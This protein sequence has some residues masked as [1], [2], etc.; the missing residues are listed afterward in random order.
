MP[1][2]SVIENVI[3]AAISRDEYERLLPSL[4]AVTLP[5]GASLYRSGDVIEHV[6]FPGKALVSLVTHMKDGVAI[7]VGVIGRDGIVGIPV[8]LGNDI[9]SEEA[10]VQIAGSAMR[11]RSTVLKQTLQGRHSA[12]LIQL[13]LYTRALMK[14]VVQT[15]ACN[16]QHTERERLARWLLMCR[17]RMESDEL[18]L[19]QDFVSDMLGIRRS[20]VTNAASNLQREG[21]IRYSPGSIKI[22]NR[23]RLEECACECYRVVAANAEKPS[24]MINTTFT[25]AVR[26]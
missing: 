23:K 13:L 17:D 1:E 10:I 2:K 8:L 4:Q 9:A 26:A 24:V 25:Q 18:L 6:Y 12:L 15:A 5:L 20:S 16:R 3:L 11:L 7:E 19:T 22:L 14:Q 21:L